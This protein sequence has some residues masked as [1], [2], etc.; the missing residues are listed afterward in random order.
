MKLDMIKDYLLTKK[1]EVAITIF[2]I[3]KSCTFPNQQPSSNKLPWFFYTDYIK[4]FYV[5]V[6][7]KPIKRKRP[8]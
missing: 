8:K 1:D 5:V 7:I 6:N 4:V 2:F 3:Y